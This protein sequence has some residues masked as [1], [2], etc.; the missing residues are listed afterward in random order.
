VESHLREVRERWGSRAVR[1]NPGL[2]ALGLTAEAAV[3]TWF[4]PLVVFCIS[5]ARPVDNPLLAGWWFLLPRDVCNE[6][7]TAERSNC[8]HVRFYFISIP[9]RNLLRR[10]SSVAPKILNWPRGLSLVH[11]L[12]P[13]RNA[14]R[15][16]SVIFARHAYL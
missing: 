5:C 16:W 14:R 7:A 13:H 11:F 6:C 8:A 2:A 10:F 1:R 9:S 3:P 4:L 15:R 12:S